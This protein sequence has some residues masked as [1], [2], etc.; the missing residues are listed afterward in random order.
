MNSFTGV[1]QRLWQQISERYFQT[2]SSGCF[3]NSG[4]KVTKNQQSNHI[5]CGMA[6]I[7]VYLTLICKY[8]KNSN[9]VLFPHDLEILWLYQI[10]YVTA[11]KG[12]WYL[13][14]IFLFLNKSAILY[15]SA[16][17]C[18]CKRSINLI[19]I[20]YLTLEDL[21]QSYGMIRGIP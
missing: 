12:S 8:I 2:L 20:G 11:T 17:V 21:W 1:F 18:K 15:Q 14:G 6:I 3:P 19:V 10:L 4:Q 16:N 9:K 5:F 7:M 13:I